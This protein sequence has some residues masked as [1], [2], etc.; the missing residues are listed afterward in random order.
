M[1]IAV[2]ASGSGTILGAMV[3]WGIDV[4]LVLV[5]RPCPGELLAQNHGLMLSKCYREDFSSSFQRVEY[6]KRVV[7]ELQKRD[8]ELVAM[9]GYGTVLGKPIHDAYPG[10][11]LNT[12]PSLL[13]AFAGWHAVREALQYG[14]R[15]TGCTVHLATL[16]VDSGPIL[17]QESVS[18][19]FGD[20]EATLHERIKQVERDLY[21]K[22]VEEYNAYLDAQPLVD[23]FSFQR[24]YNA[25]RR[26]AK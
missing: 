26:G 9:A 7:E 2:L 18:V 12:H 6:T 1:K 24:A 19:E 21:P 15:V 16:D 10:R 8:I 22:T 17:A 13:P 11:I 5:D 14:V 4:S 20:D 3:G 23:F 25:V